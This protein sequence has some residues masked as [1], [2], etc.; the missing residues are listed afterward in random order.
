MSN[1]HRCDVTDVELESHRHQ[2]GIANLD[3]APDVFIKRFLLIRNQFSLKRATLI[4]DYV[5]ESQRMIL[6]KI[7]ADYFAFTVEMPCRLCYTWRA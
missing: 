5:V 3:A 2:R 4:P 6:Q 7:D 1:E